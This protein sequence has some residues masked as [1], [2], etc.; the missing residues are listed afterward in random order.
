MTRASASASAFS[1]SATRDATPRDGLG[2]GVRSLLGLRLGALDLGLD[3]GGEWPRARRPRGAELGRR[4]LALG[5]GGMLV[6]EVEAGHVRLLLGGDG[7]DG[8][9]DQVDEAA[10]DE[11]RLELA[12]VD[13]DEQVDDS[14]VRS[15]SV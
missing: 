3:V 7:G 8:D 6:R 13:G 10:L 4:R 1:A 5:G 11:L 9:L 12:E 14:G 15:S 2:G